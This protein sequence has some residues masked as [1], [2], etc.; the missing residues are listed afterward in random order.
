VD[1]F[2]IVRSGG[3]GPFAVDI[4]FPLVQQVSH[5][6]LRVVEAFVAD[7]PLAFGAPKALTIGA[8]PRAGF[9]RLR[10]LLEKT[11]ARNFDQSII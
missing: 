8:K 6:A 4:E 7:E 2:Q 1:D 10:F 9:S 5:L 11:I 3:L